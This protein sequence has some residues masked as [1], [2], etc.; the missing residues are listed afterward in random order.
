M[1][2]GTSLDNILNDEPVSDAVEPQE[3]QMAP[4][5]QEEPQTP[6][7]G[8]V[9]DEKGR[10]AAKGVDDTGSPPDKLPQEEYREVRKEREKRQT[11][12]RELQALREQFQ[13]IQQP[14]E[15]PAP[16]PSLWE[17]EE[18]WQQ[19]FGSQV[20]SAASLNARLD[21]SEMLASQNH[22]DFD[23]MKDRF[24]QMMGQN[25][26]LQQQALSAKH[27]WEKAYQIAK[28]AAKMEELA[29]VDLDDL[30]AKMRE[31]LM[32]EMQG[33]TPAAPTLPPTLTT[34][35]NVGTRS[36]PAWSGPR[37]LSEL[38]G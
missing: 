32:A 36:G 19:H 1:E 6:S 2:E 35:R 15:P 20:A 30:K 29:A 11:V 34:E 4:E 23:E 7:D 21:M 27:P 9:R 13:A 12:E 28:N 3:A 26:T 37:P 8:P 31:E 5:P 18:G 16:P 33:Q 14:K 38:L 24:I 25:P 17:D 22:D 10:F